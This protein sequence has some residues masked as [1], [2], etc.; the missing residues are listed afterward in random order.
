[1][2]FNISKAE[3]ILGDPKAGWETKKLLWYGG[4]DRAVEYLT[5]TCLWH[6]MTRSSSPIPIRYVLVKDIENKFNP[7]LLMSTDLELDAKDIIETYVERWNVEVTLHESREHLGIETQRQWSDR[8]I[9]RTTPILF[10][11]YSLVV[12]MGN[13][14]IQQGEI[15][16]EQTAW[17]AK[18]EIKFSD[19]LRGVRK[20][21]LKKMY[22]CKDVLQGGTVEKSYE[23][24][25]V[26]AMD[27]FLLAA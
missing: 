22:F 1:V 27:L 12:L 23:N 14:L 6:V 20:H 11:L 8:A 4:V 21:L 9:A 13:S 2:I 10:A 24:L 3:D 15:E 17:Y 26:R 19:I 16:I 7:V 5:G 25:M 18:Q